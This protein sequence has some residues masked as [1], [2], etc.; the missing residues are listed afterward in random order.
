MSL[1]LIGR[2]H[3]PLSSPVK[4]KVIH[5]TPLM[6]LGDDSWYRAHTE[7]IHWTQDLISIVSHGP[8]PQ[9]DPD[10]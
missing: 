2:S 9:R 7:N 1:I 10:V 5:S 4:Q 6:S 8:D 3:I